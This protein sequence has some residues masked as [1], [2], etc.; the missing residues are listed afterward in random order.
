[1]RVR[2]TMAVADKVARRVGALLRGFKRDH[3]SQEIYLYPYLNGRERGYALQIEN[4]LPTFIFSE[5][6]G[7]DDIVVYEDPDWSVFGLGIPS[8]E[9][10]KNS[11]HFDWR[12]EE[13]AAKYIV[14]RIKKLVPPYDRKMERKRKQ[15]EKEEAEDPMCNLGLRA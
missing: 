1:M 11:K 15:W 8:E 4:D 3:Y 9:A 5:S 10:F 14:S 12:Q 7:S 13:K 2:R 6:R